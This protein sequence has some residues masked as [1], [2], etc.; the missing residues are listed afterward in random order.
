[1]ARGGKFYLYYSAEGP[2]PG[3]ADHLRICVATSNSPAGPFKDVKAPLLEIGKSVIDAEAFVDDD[4]KG[5]L[6]YALDNSENVVRDPKTGKEI[7]QSHIYVVKLGN[8]LVSVVGPPVFCTRP[9]HK[10]E[11]DT[12]N[13]GPFVFKHDR[14]YILMYSA[15]AFFEPEYCLGYATAESPLGPWTKADRPVLET[16]ASATVSGPGHNCVIDSPDGKETFCVYHEHKNVKSPGGDRELAIDRM[17]FEE[18]D[19]TESS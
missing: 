11:G 1:M 16:H 7:H 2:V 19:E 6:Y 17:T 9:D 18:A 8:D 14:T 13:E 12:V 15:H 5:Y 3:G 4:G 10:W